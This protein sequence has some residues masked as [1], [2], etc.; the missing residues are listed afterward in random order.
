M[1][2]DHNVINIDCNIVDPYISNT[3]FC[4]TIATFNNITNKQNFLYYYPNNRT[5]YKLRGNEIDSINI[6]ISDKDYNQLNPPQIQLLNNLKRL[7]C[8]QYA[9]VLF[10][11]A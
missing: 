2:N 5:F 4:N 7:I 8:W 3:K 10:H 6:K 11:I 1:S 9:I